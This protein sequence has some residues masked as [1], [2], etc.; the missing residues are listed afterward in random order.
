MLE[1]SQLSRSQ[2]YSGFSV[3]DIDAAR[4]FYGETLGLTVRDGGMGA[5]LLELGSG[6]VVYLYPKRN[7][8]PA[9]YTVLN[10]PVDDIEAAVDELVAA[11]VV[12]ARY[13]GAHQDAKGIARGKSV[14][15]GPDI[16]WFT[17]PAG[18]VLSVMEN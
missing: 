9:T 3:D 6:A 4:A 17:D 8:E 10:F 12:F 15:Q 5:I 1:K 7:H 18:N 16:A 13:E 11:G 2:A 14:D